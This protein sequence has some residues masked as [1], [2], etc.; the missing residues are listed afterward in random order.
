M[1]SKTVGVETKIEANG[2]EAKKVTVLMRGTV[3][4]SLMW[5]RMAANG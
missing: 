4:N 2:K 1:I 5:R 3:K